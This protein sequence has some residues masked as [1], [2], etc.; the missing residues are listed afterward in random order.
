MVYASSDSYT[1]EWKNGKKNGN[2]T[3]IIGKNPDGQGINI[4]AVERG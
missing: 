2:G 4:R 1:G 3:Y